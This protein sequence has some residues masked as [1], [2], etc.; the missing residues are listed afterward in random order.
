MAT[1][2][3]YVS[4]STVLTD[5]NHNHDLEERHLASKFPLCD[6][7]DTQHHWIRECAEGD[8]VIERTNCR[9]A[10]QQAISAERDKRQS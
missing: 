8:L 6:N 10:L 5:P 4:N 9:A 1:N 7:I 2:D 3:P